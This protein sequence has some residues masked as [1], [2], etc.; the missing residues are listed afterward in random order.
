MYRLWMGNV[1]LFLQLARV[2]VKS[3]C[4]GGRSM[5]S[6]MLRRVQPVWQPLRPC[7]NWK[8]GNRKLKRY[9]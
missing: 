2:L 9:G 7:R 8:R 6:M 3:V 1:I 5:A 4:P